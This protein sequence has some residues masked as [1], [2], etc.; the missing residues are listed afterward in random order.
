MEVRELWH[1]LLQKIGLEDAVKN[2]RSTSQNDC[3]YHVLR[4]RYASDYATDYS[5]TARCNDSE[6]RIRKDAVESVKKIPRPFFM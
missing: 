5:L 4:N 2:H 6:A 1:R 3:S